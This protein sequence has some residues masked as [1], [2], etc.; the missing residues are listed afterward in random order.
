MCEGNHG[1]LALC[2]DA[3]GQVPPWGGLHARSQALK[4]GSLRSVT[5]P[6]RPEGPC[7]KE[8]RVTGR[9]WG[10]HAAIPEAYN[11]VQCCQARGPLPCPCGQTL[12]E[13]AAWL[14]DRMAI[15]D[16]V[17]LALKGGPHGLQ[18][19]KVGLLLRRLDA[20]RRRHLEHVVPV[21]LKGSARQRQTAGQ[22]N[23]RDGAA[24]SSGQE[25]HKGCQEQ[26]RAAAGPSGL[27]ASS[28]RSSRR[29]SWGPAGRPPPTCCP[30]AGQHEGPHTTHP[31]ASP[32]S[33][34]PGRPPP[35]CCP[36]CICSGKAQA[37]GP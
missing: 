3:A 32:A 19:S 7:V 36:Q 33:L 31:P 4:D 24:R 9:P 22:R 23:N 26:A 30:H 37:P 34:A 15:P 21:A 13:S 14:L 28:A 1:S 10:A 5:A 8:R 20:R 29:V 6:A 16:K 25:R 17:A 11:H 35:T 27:N 18:G 2:D 12:G